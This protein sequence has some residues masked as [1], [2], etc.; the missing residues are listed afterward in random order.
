MQPDGSWYSDDGKYVGF[1]V[2]IP[3]ESDLALDPDPEESSA[4]KWWDP[5]DLDDPEVRDKVVES[6]ELIQPLLKATLKEFH[7]FTDTIIDHYHTQVQAALRHVFSDAII[8]EA[9]SAGY[10]SRIP[11]L[12]NDGAPV[13]GSAGKAGEPCVQKGVLDVARQILQAAKRSI[14]KLIEVLWNL[15]ADAAVQG[16]HEA[17][18]AA[19]GT[20]PPSLAIDLPEGYWEHW[21]PGYAPAAAL[22]TNGLADILREADIW[23][24]ELVDT[25]INRIGDE[26]ARGI[27][28]GEPISETTTRVNHIVNDAKRAWLITET[29]YARAMTLAARR[30][31]LANNVPAVAWLAQPDACP[32]C[33]ANVAVSPIA[34]TQQ[35]P[36]GDVPVHPRCRCAEAPAVRVPRAP[37]ML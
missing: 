1:V 37:L 15:Y 21:R 29:E 17:A 6:L 9:I 5:D 3:N 36:S 11:M 26:I 2:Q 16:A 32:R 31:Y 10:E 33:E 28:T 25:Q 22:L 27:E 30:T 23:I 8:Q 34:L 19:G 7:R 4:A 14:A 20:V 12:D 35:W 18:Q 13:V 24:N